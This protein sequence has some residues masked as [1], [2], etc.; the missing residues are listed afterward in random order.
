MKVKAIVLDIDGTLINKEKVILNK[1]KNIIKK[2][3]KIGIKIILASG[4]PTS[5]IIQYAKELEL[6]K[7]NGYI[8]S[9][10]GAKVVS[11]EDNKVHLNETLDKK[12]TYSI[13]KHLENYNVIT[14]IDNDEYLFVKDV[15][16]NNINIHGKNFNII[17]SE[18]EDNQLKICELDNLYDYTG[19]LNKILVAGD[20]EFLQNNILDIIKPFKAQINAEFSEDYLLE[21]S[22][23]NIHKA[24]GLQV[25]LEE[26]NILRKDI[27]TFGD[28]E[29][30]ISMLDYS[31]VSVAMENANSKVK[32]YADFITTSNEEDGIAETIKQ[33]VFENNLRRKFK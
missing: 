22:K 7:N 25:A 2:A 19:E 28:G 18:K 9:Y 23:K 29:N 30:D 24:K 31:G 10:N 8:V 27:I 15:Y 4:R 21:I 5:G 11:T 13:L 14:F 6:E 26:L 20:T 17:K 12:L 32:K 1:T 3:Q 33:I 16:K